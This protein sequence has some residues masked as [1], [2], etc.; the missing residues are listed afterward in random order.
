M[1]ALE[2]FRKDVFLQLRAA[3]SIIKPC[4]K[5]AWDLVRREWADLDQQKRILYEDLAAATKIHC[6]TSRA[7]RVSRAQV[8]DQDHCIQ[9]VIAIE[10]GDANGPGQT[11]RYRLLSRR[12]GQRVFS[13]SV[14]LVGV[15]NGAG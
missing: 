14:V 11:M 1:S 8:A 6:R 5:A 7:L 2:L 12:H 10:D 9:D 15:D 4:S 13:S 3:D